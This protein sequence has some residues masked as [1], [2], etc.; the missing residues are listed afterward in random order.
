MGRGAELLMSG[1]LKAVCV[2]T[3][4]KRTEMAAALVENLRGQGL[5]EPVV[6][7]DEEM[8][9]TALWCAVRAWRKLVEEARRVEA[10]PEDLVLMVQDDAVPCRDVQ[11]GIE[12]THRIIGYGSRGRFFSHGD[13]TVMSGKARE[14]GTHWIRSRGGD[15]YGFANSAHFEAAAALSAWFDLYFDN[16]PPR[17]CGQKWH[18]DWLMAAFTKLHGGFGG[19][20]TPVPTLF[21]H[22]A[23]MDSALK[24]HN[25]PKKVSR[26]TLAPGGSA[27]DVRWYRGADKPVPRATGYGGQRAQVAEVREVQAAIRSR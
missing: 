22:G 21:D 7:V 9:G 25:N 24:G 11:Y 5:P 2:M 19:S 26:W 17:K 1:T 27:L 23:P 3:C 14:R 20:F 18:D 13:M 12:R 15:F 4:A 16:P 6:M 10:G 8:R